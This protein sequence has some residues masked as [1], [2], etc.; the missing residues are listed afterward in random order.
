MR[1]SSLKSHFR[2]GTCSFPPVH[3]SRTFFVPLG[4]R[5]TV[6][7]IKEKTLKTG[8]PKTSAISANDRTYSESS[9]LMFSGCCLRHQAQ[10]PTSFPGSSLRILPREFSKEERDRL[11][12]K[13]A[14]EASSLSG[15]CH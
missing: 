14:W 10:P 5:P 15:L 4:I 13:R 2:R 1:W 11:L 3:N 7:V 9:I 8:K 6:P 12:Q